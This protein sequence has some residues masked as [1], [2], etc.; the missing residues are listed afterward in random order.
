[1]CTA[2]IIIAANY[3]E[4]KVFVLTS[5]IENTAETAGVQLSVFMV[6]T[7]INVCHA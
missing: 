6:R 2:V 5:A 1:M 4:E 7:G 3:V